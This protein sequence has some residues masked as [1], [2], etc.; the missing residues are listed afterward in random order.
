[1]AVEV[2]VKISPEMFREDVDR[3]RSWL[4]KTFPYDWIE[5]RAAG[6]EDSLSAADIVLTAVLTVAAE[7]AKDA[8]VDLI[9]TK[10]GE[11][12]ERYKNRHKDVPEVDVEAN[13]LAGQASSPPHTPPDGTDR[14][15]S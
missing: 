7:T 14:D 8:A 15:A 2:V 1:M 9:R 6:G 10:I 13:D 11:L 4:E 3:L 5:S 12:V